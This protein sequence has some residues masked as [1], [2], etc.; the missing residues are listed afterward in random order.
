MVNLYIVTF[1]V[2]SSNSLRIMSLKSDL[3]ELFFELSTFSVFIMKQVFPQNRPGID[4]F[5]Q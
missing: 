1:N 4:Q 2:R 3:K 5:E